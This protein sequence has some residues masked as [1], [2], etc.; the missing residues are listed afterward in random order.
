MRRFSGVR[1]EE[2]KTLTQKALFE[3]ELNWVSK[4]K[5]TSSLLSFDFLLRE[6]KKR[7]DPSKIRSLSSLLQTLF[8][9]ERER[10]EKLNHHVFKRKEEGTHRRTFGGLGLVQSTTEIFI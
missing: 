2:E 6:A 3:N 4:F 1:N 5:K 8:Y 9:T 10:A 7:A